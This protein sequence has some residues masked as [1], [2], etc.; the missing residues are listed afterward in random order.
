MDRIFLRVIQA[1][2]SPFLFVFVAALLRLLPHPPNVAP[3]AALA[4]FG[5]V[6]LGKR[7]ALAVPLGAMLISDIFLGFHSTMPYVYGSFAITGLLGLWL[8]QHKTPRNIIAITFGSSLLF[9]LVTNF[10]VWA[11][12][13]LYPKTLD[14]LMLSY[15]MGIPFFRNTLAGDFFFV[16]I[17][18]GG[19]E[20]ARL[21]ARH[22]RT[23]LS[24]QNT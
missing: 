10:G 14:G 22:L 11:S 20:L 21:G 24:A 5:G 17:L 7:Y 15:T 23:R 16:A 12:S 18:F 9:F 13:T 8:A 1:A 4:L 19:Y 2:A 6:Y 3:I